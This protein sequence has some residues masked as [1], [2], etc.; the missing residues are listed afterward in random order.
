MGQRSPESFDRN[1]VHAHHTMS[2]GENAPGTNHEG[3]L[4]IRMFSLH[5]SLFTV[6]ANECHS[7]ASSATTQINYDSSKLGSLLS[8]R[9]ILHER[10][11]KSEVALWLSNYNRAVRRTEIDS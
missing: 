11:V 7:R 1:L 8:T 2:R 3:A 10:T 5:S 6:R 4:H 9:E